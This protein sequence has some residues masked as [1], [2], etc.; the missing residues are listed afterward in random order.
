M[1]PILSK[2]S[3]PFPDCRVYFVS[4]NEFYVELKG[5]REMAARCE[6][7]G[8]G[9]MVGNHVSH[10]K[11]RKKRRFSPNLKRVH[12]MVEGTPT[13]LKVCTKCIKIGRITKAA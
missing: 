5:G 11:N 1:S 2:K 6:I 8:K 7:C 3:L 9:P 4:L 10:A 12:A 13:R